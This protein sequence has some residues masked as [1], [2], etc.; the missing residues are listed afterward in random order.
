MTHRLE[1]F[2]VKEPCC[3][4]FRLILIAGVIRFI[5]E[6]QTVEIV[7]SGTIGVSA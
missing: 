7:S 3:G 2:P 4:R 5:E 6:S 1:E